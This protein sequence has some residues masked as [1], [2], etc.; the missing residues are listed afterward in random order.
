MERGTYSF[1]IYVEKVVNSADKNARFVDSIDLRSLYTTLSEHDFKIHDSADDDDDDESND[2]DSTISARIKYRVFDSLGSSARDLSARLLDHNLEVV[3]T[4]SE[5][6]VPNDSLREKVDIYPFEGDEKDG[7]WRVLF[8]AKDQHAAL[9]RDHQDRSI[10]AL[11]QSAAKQKIYVLIDPGHGR[12]FYGSDAA[13]K[14]LYFHDRDGIWTTY[15]NNP[16]Y[17]STDYRLLHEGDTNYAQAVELE[18]IL[19]T[20]KRNK[21]LYKSRKTRSSVTYEATFDSL[22]QA[23]DYAHKTTLFERIRLASDWYDQIEKVYADQNI[24]ESPHVIMISVHT[25]ADASNKPSG[26]EVFYQNGDRSSSLAASIFNRMTKKN[27]ATS[28]G[29][30]L[31]GRP[32]ENSRGKYANDK[33]LILKQNNGNLPKI[34]RVIAEILFHTNTVPVDGRPAEFSLLRNGLTWTEG[35]VA[36]EGGDATITQTGTWWGKAIGMRALKAAVDDY[37]KEYP[38]AP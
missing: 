28:P 29:G 31:N 18:K 8:T 5:S 22:S 25:N 37:R 38:T 7:L 21:N 10:L 13:G 20:G 19:G 15:P 27:T 11:N 30:D 17:P 36:A 35:T 4:Y 24:K 14:P 23:V 12:A 34:P 1:D 32:G 3:K 16:P 9:Y 26:T 33:Y 6:L 2:E